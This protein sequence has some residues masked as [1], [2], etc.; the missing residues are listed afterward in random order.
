MLAQLNLSLVSRSDNSYSDPALRALF[1]LNNHNYVINA[2]RRSSLMELL[3]LAEP[4]AEQ[5]YDDLLLRNQINY[6]SATF[7]KVKVPIENANDDTGRIIN[8]IITKSNIANVLHQQ[9]KKYNSLF[10][11]IICFFTELGSKT[12]KEKFT[13]FTKEFDEVA[14]HQR[15]FSVPDARLR[16]DLRKELCNSLTPVYV[17]FYN[18]Y[19]KTSFS[20]NPGKYIKYTPE[21]VLTTIKTFFDGTT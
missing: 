17:E 2:L 15:S 9:E 18:K 1:R 5:T 7:S 4:N 20:K 21:Q 19:R 10:D 11:K 6:V 13:A 14:K 12:I 16:S 8:F 3:L